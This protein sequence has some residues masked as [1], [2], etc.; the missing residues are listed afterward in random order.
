ML[1]TVSTVSVEL[2]CCK[3]VL[4]SCKTKFILLNFPSLVL[5]LFELLSCLKVF[6]Q[7]FYQTCKTLKQTILLNFNGLKF[8]DYLYQEEAA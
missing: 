3:A 6:T 2:I 7:I 8:L 4:I 5:A 1:Q